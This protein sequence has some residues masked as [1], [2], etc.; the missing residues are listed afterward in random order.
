VDI[1]YNYLSGTFPSIDSLRRVRQFSISSNFF[2]GTL[3]DG[4]HPLKWNLTSFFNVANNY[5]VGPFPTLTSGVLRAVYANNNGFTGTIPSSPFEAHTLE[6]FAASIN[7][8]HGQLPSNMCGAEHLIDIEL[9]GLHSSNLCSKQLSILGHDISIDGVTG[10]IN[11][12]LFALPRLSILHMSGNKFTGTLS[13]TTIRA[14]NFTEVRLSFNELVGTIPSFLWNGNFSLMDFSFNRFNGLIESSYVPATPTATL[15]LQRNQLSGKVPR[16]I[17]RLQNIRVLEGNLFSCKVDRSDLPVHDPL[18]NTYSCGSDSINDALYIWYGLLTLVMLVVAWFSSPIAHRTTFVD[19]TLLF[20]WW[21][22]ATDSH[23]NGR[24]LPLWL[25]SMIQFML[26]D[27][28]LARWFYCLS[29]VLV[30]SSL[31]YIGLSQN[32]G[33]YTY[34]YGW[35]VTGIFKVGLTPTMVLLVVYALIMVI[36]MGIYRTVLAQTLQAEVVRLSLL[37]NA[38]KKPW[39]QSITDKRKWSSFGMLLINVCIVMVVNVAFVLSLGKSYSFIVHTMISVF[40]SIFKIYWSMLIVRRFGVRFNESAV[41]VISVFNNVVAPY[42][43]VL[44]SSPN[45]FTYIIQTTPALVTAVKDMR[46]RTF[47]L[48]FLR[49]CHEVIECINTVRSNSQ[50]MEINYHPPFVYSYQCSSS[51]LSTFSYVFVYRYVFSGLIA[52]LWIVVVKYLQ[53]RLIKLRWKLLLK[54]M[55]S[56]IPVLWRP[57]WTD[58][59]QEQVVIA[60]DWTV[61][62]DELCRSRQS[63]LVPLMTDVSILIAFG[64]PIPP[65]AMLIMISMFVSVISYVLSIGRLLDMEA[66]IVDI[67]CLDN[68][69]ISIEVLGKLFSSWLSSVQN[70]LIV[71]LCIAAVVWSFL[72][73]DTLGSSRDGQPAIVIVCVLLGMTVCMF[74]G[75]VVVFRNSF[76]FVNNRSVQKSIELT[77]QVCV[78]V[79]WSDRCV[80]N[81]VDFAILLG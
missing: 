41:L 44:F 16:S 77:V 9:D 66:S 45:C 56:T 10:T 63:L 23:N 24:S 50:T 3:S 34:S 12:C 21:A 74:V 53:L 59:Q 29:S 73:F 35:V 28:V 68:I 55:L 43:A 1:G 67:E 70:G 36:F 81:D 69:R 5:F 65:L 79:L 51:V 60:D 27:V 6:I 71:A 80:I 17:R 52:P 25:H 37:Q 26:C 76:V 31:V 20:K 7:C 39:T 4:I 30:V 58:G 62:V 47:A 11:S 49:D 40:L 14:K 38:K 22:L 61:L 18:M 32:F 72:L 19:M 78:E 13:N 2:E 33:S 46:C 8:L 15:Y 48:C 54:P 75:T 64:V 57:I 42:L